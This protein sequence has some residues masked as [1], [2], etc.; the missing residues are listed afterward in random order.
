L[1][2]FNPGY[3]STIG[4]NFQPINFTTNSKQIILNVWDTSEQETYRCLVPMYLRGADAALI[5]YDVTNEK[6][7]CDLQE[8]Y[9]QLENNTSDSIIT[10]LI[11]NKIDFKENQ[12]IDENIAKEFADSHRSE[13]RQTSAKT[14]DG[15]DKMF[16]DVANMFLKKCAEE[17]QVSVPPPKLKDESNEGCC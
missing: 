4:E 15:V 8:W 9:D 11:E 14:G 5:V 13:Y 16:Y 6:T 17:I 2:F 10:F 1:Q 7:F 3:L 12:G